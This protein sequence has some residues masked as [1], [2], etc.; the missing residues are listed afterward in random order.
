MF[1]DK[2]LHLNYDIIMHS[3]TSLWSV[4]HTF[5]VRLLFAKKSKVRRLRVRLEII[6]EKGEKAWMRF[7][8]AFDLIIHVLERRWWKRSKKNSVW[9]S[10]WS[11]SSWLIIKHAQKQSLCMYA[12]VIVRRAR[13]ASC[14]HE[15][16]VY[17]P[18]YSNN[19]YRLIAIKKKA[20]EV[21]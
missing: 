13:V 15:L 19:Y 3:N 4:L 16:L 17:E 8:F 6:L 12:V 14:L 11:S 5:C 2:N 10:Q 9:A 20:K 21:I 7:Y 18:Y 1:P